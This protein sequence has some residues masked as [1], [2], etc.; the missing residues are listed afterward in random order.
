MEWLLA[1]SPFVLALIPLVWSDIIRPRV[2][3]KRPQPDP[4]VTPSPAQDTADHVPVVIGETLDM[5]GVAVETLTYSRDR[6]IADLADERKRHTWCHR[7]M[8]D[9]GVPVPHD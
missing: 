7:V 8:R 2:R 5:T 4:V 6:A 1:L 9:A 3:P